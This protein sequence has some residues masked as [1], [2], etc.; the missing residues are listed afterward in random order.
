MSERILLTVREAADRLGIGRSTAYELIASGRLAGR[1]GVGHGD[2]DGFAVSIRFQMRKLTPP[3]AVR[4]AC[5]AGLVLRPPSCLIVEVLTEADSS[6]IFRQR[7]RGFCRRGLQHVDPR[8]SGEV[9]VGAHD[10]AC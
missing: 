6:I 7:L 8:R 3:D 9:R 4:N 2:D 10:V 5:S 1:E